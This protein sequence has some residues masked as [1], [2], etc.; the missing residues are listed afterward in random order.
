MESAFFL[1]TDPNQVI[2][3]THEQEQ[4]RLVQSCERT[5]L[6]STEQ[7]LEENSETRTCCKCGKVCKG[8]R[9]FHMHY[10]KAHLKKKRHVS[11]QL[12]G[13][14][15]THKYGMRFHLKQVHSHVLRVS[16]TVCGVVLY[17]KYA[18]PKHM[19]KFHP[20]ETVTS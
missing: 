15:F 4:P 13:R 3:P 17:N 16:C 10:T 11:C 5:V 20:E 12:C 9:G 8:T 14:Q 6:S 18:L 1:F 2:I 19:R 7:A